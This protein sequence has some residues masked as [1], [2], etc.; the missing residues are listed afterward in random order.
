MNLI[1]PSTPPLDIGRYLRP[2]EA[3]ILIVRHH[4]ALLI[5][6]L[7]AALGGLLAA[8]ATSAIPQSAKSPQIVVWIL[9]AFLTVRFILATFNWAVEY[10]VL[11]DQRLLVVTG[12]FSRRFSMIAISRLKEMALQRTVAG[13]L[14]GYGAFTIELDGK[15]RPVVDYIPFPDQVYLEVYEK[16]SPKDRTTTDLPPPPDL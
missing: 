6:S 5:P 2:D 4:P 13:R 15:T 11:T 12:L 7:T 10:M 16:I 1:A 14:L 3:L 9:T 8:A